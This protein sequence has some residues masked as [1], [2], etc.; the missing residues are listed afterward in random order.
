M[1]KSQQHYNFLDNKVNNILIGIKPMRYG[2]NSMRYSPKAICLELNNCKNQ[3]QEDISVTNYN[4]E[5]KVLCDKLDNFR[6]LP[7]YECDIK[8][9][10][11][12]LLDVKKHMIKDRVIKFLKGLND[13]YVAKDNYLII[14]PS[15]QELD[16]KV[17]VVSNNW[18]K[19][20]FPRRS[21]N[22]NKSSTSGFGRS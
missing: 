10:C 17:L 19:G 22:S 15:R 8:C 3:L 1:G 9:S 13:V 6:P 4:I 21:Q 18:R 2:M 11:N 14:T 16:S 5:S 7:K 12:V 20:S